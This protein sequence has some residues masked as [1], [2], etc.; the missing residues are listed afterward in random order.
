MAI[1]VENVG[2]EPYKLALQQLAIKTSK[3]S[4]FVLYPNPTD[5]ELYI[6]SDIPIEKADVYNLQGRLLIS[7]NLKDGKNEKVTLDLSG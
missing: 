3:V 4:S 5:S 6:S 2:I 1:Y 7:S